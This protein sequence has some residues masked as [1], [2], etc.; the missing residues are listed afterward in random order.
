MDSQNSNRKL[1]E[2]INKFSDAAGYKKFVQIN[3]FFNITTNLQKDH[4]HIPTHN[5]LKES[6]I[7][8]NKLNQGSEGHENFKPLKKKTLKKKKKTQENERHPMLRDW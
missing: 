4:E 2:I 5:T 8:I 7:S 3:S 6:K 1:L